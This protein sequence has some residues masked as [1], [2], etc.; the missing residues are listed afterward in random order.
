MSRVCGNAGVAKRECQPLPEKILELLNF[1]PRPF[2]QA[3][4]VLPYCFYMVVRCT[5]RWFSNLSLNI[6]ASLVHWAVR[7][8]NLIILCQKVGTDQNL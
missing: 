6:R 8:L 4:K 1:P 7:A 2:F 3:V 5:G